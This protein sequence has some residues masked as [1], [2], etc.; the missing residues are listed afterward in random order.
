MLTSEIFILFLFCFFNFKFFVFYFNRLGIVIF[1]SIAP[2]LLSS[3]FVDESLV[4]SP[5]A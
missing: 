5:T 4:K 2:R 1:W 3:S